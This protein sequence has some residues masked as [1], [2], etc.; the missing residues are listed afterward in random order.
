M[1]EATH[2]FREVLKLE[3][4]HVEGNYNLGTILVAQGKLG[5][6]TGQ[7]FRS[8]TQS[9]ADTVRDRLFAHLKSALQQT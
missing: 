8:W 3:P 1:W 6:K 7:G 2:H 5:M 9:E 4:D